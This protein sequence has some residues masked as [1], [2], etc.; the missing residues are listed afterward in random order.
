MLTYRQKQGY[1][2]VGQCDTKS[3]DVEQDAYVE[4]RKSR[5]VTG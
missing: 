3:E 2:D 5:S 4:I 1:E